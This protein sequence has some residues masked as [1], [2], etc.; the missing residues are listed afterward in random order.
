ME[1]A[2]ALSTKAA[3]PETVPIPTTAARRDLVTRTLVEVMVDSEASTAATLSAAKLSV[4]LQRRARLRLA[5]RQREAAVL[6]DRRK[7]IMVFRRRE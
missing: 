3:I 1:V 2:V 6:E 5:R 7:L 4:D